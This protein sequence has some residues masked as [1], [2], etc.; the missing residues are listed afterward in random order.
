M[1]KDKEK[2]IKKE[3]SRKSEAKENV[4]GTKVGQGTKRRKTASACKQLIVPKDPREVDPST[5]KKKASHPPIPK[6]K[7][8]TKV[9]TSILQIL[10]GSPKGISSVVINSL[11]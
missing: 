3:T 11:A 6:T 9:E 5:A 1:G 7:V 8:K 10:V 4:E 2:K